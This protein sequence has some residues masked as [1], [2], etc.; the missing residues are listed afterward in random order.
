MAKSSRLADAAEY[1]P[2]RQRL[3]DRTLRQ[4][5]ALDPPLAVDK[6]AIAL[7]EGL[8]RQNVVGQFRNAVIE[9]VGV[10]NGLDLTEPGA[11]VRIVIEQL[12]LRHDQ[13]LGRIR[14]D[15]LRRSGRIAQVVQAHAVG[16]GQR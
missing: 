15:V 16:A 3:P 5:E 1:F 4:I 11:R 9:E 7:G 13:R 10:D 12:G 8:Q 14:H 6:A 2:G